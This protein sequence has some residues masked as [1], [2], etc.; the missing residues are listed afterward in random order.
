MYNSTHS[1]RQYCTRNNVVY[2]KHMFHASKYLH[3]LDDLATT[4][5]SSSKSAS[6]DLTQLELIGLRTGY[7][8]VHLC[9]SAPD[10]EISA[11]THGFIF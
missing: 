3:H 5:T 6:T 1:I 11:K 8:H 2:D 4:D 10:M 7:I 9:K